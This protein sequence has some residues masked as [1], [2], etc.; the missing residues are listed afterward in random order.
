MRPVP[1]SGPGGA[2]GGSSAWPGQ[3]PKAPSRPSSGYG[4]PAARPSFQPNGYQAPA[5]QAAPAGGRPQ[6]RGG[7]W[8][9]RTERIER[10]PASGYPDPRPERT[11]RAPAPGYTDQRTERIERVP[12]SG[13]PDP[14]PAARGQG[15]ASATGGSPAMGPGSSVPV[16]PP[17]AAVPAAPAAAPRH[18]RA[19][20]GRAD[21]GRADSARSDSARN[22][23]ARGD[24]LWRMPERAEAGREAGDSIWS[25]SGRDT[26]PARRDDPLTSS[27]YSRSALSETDGRSYRVAARR[28]QAQAQLTDQAEALVNGSYQ[29]GSYPGYA[30]YSGQQPAASYEAATARPAQH[31]QR[32]TQPGQP[33]NPYDGGTGSY[34][35]PGSQPYAGQPGSPAAAGDPDP[36][37]RPQA[38]EAGPGGGESRADQSPRNPGRPGFPPGYGAGRRPY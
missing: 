17:G 22:G 7:D 37:Y 4:Q 13:Y 8:G 20:S 32:E 10:V 19:D 30:G 12:A 33:Q 16:R 21:S 38:R 24:D 27:A 9:E 25:G 28:S 18:S 29:Q 31:L 2:R 34:P 23:S 6:D 35:Y 3:P 11:E 5:A 14:R 1:A 36:Y 15:T 26:G